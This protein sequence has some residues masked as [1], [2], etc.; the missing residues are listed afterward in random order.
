M[1]TAVFT[2]VT[3]LEM[4]GRCKYNKTVFINIIVFF[5]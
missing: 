1:A 4:I 5:F 2:A 3:S